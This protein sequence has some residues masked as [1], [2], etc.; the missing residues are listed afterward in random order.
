MKIATRCITE[1]YNNG[2]F[3]TIVLTSG[4]CVHTPPR[5]EGYE[6]SISFTQIE[7]PNGE[8]AE[9]IQIDIQ[10]IEVKPE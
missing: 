3:T 6:A 10:P 4:D 1:I 5:H 9:A 8:L 2:D 7:T